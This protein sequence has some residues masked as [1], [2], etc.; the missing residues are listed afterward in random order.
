MTRL[1]DLPHRERVAIVR[2]EIARVAERLSGLEPD[3]L[4]HPAMGDWAIRD[5]IAHLMVVAE[6][7]ADSIARGAG[8]DTA[9]SGH[10][11]AA[12][13]G[14]GEIAATSIRE[15]A[16]E[17]AGALDDTV[18]DR[19]RAAA[20]ALTDALDLDESSLE[21]QCYHPGGV[22]TANQ[23]V[24]LFL[25][26]LGLHEWDMFEAIEAP[27]QMSGWGVDAT[28]QALEDEVASGSLRWATDPGASPDTITIRVITAGAVALERDLVLEP[29]RTLLVEVDDQ[30]RVD[31]RLTIDAAD[32]VLGTSGRLDFVAAVTNG[33]AKGDPAAIRRLADRLTGM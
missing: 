18:I 32:F 33:R 21:Y 7:Y 9:V 1:W 20:L 28:L 5:V 14:R 15:R 11:P 2:Q 30:R 26:E 17:V 31:S 29:D 25:K 3:Q 10:G 19:F 8:G 6:F 13:T 23:F 4:D 24:V 12:G 16:V 22:L 27:C